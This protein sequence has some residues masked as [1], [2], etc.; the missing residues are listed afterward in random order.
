MEGKRIA[1]AMSGGVDSTVT[2]A[3]MREKGG[4]VQGVFMALAQ[5]DLDRQIARVQKSADFLGIPLTIIDLATEFAENIQQYF[6]QSYLG[7]LTPNPCVVCNKTIKFGRLLDHVT[8]LGCDYM[9]TGHYAR[10]V[11]DGQGIRHLLQGKDAKKDQSYFLNQLS[12]AQLGRLLFPLGE[13][14]K[15]GVYDIAASLGLKFKRSEESQDICFLNES[16]AQFLEAQDLVLPGPGDIVDP[17]GVKLG[18]HKG[19]YNFTIGQRRGLGIPDATPYYV[20]DLKAESNT[21]VVGKE[22][23]LWRQECLVGEMNWPAGKQPPLPGE[24]MVKIRYRH[25]GACATVEACGPRQVRIIFAEGQ[26]AITP[27]QFA[28]IYVG[29]QV[30][31][32][33]RVLPF[34]DSPNHGKH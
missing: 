10:I 15:D 1:V 7:G 3:L 8:A 6:S 13:M 17:D 16:V 11:V 19:I 29:E 12:Q 31:G 2:A 30:Q 32:G 14:S 34:V 26:R 24:F 28:V 27:G 33:G 21:V 5:P 4:I 18:R 20:I 25:Q 9:A 23:D 22:K